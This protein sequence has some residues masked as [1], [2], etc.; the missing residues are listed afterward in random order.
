MEKHEFIATVA[1][2]DKAI[3]AL[4]TNAASFRIQLLETE[5]AIAN[6]LDQKRRFES[7]PANAP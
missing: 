5:N 1:A 7:D 2:F 6:L 3:K 4:Q